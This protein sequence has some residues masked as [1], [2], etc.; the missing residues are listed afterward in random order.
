M[1]P[2]LST[3]HELP[4]IRRGWPGTHGTLTFEQYDESGRLRAGRIHADGTVTLAEYASDPKLPELAPPTAGELVVHR[5]GKRGVIIYEHSVRKF[6]RPQ[7]VESVA[8]ATHAAHELCAPTGIRTAQVIT[9]TPGSLSTEKLPGATL[10]QLAD[11]GLAGWRRFGQL[12]PEVVRQRHHCAR[13]HHATSECQ[14]LQE[15]LG[16]ATRFG[17]IPAPE[18]CQQLVAEICNELQQP[19]GE[20]VVCHRDLHDK[21]LLWDGHDL[22]L[23]DTD[24]LTMAEAALDLGNLLAHAELRY[25]QG[26]LSAASLQQVRD[27]LHTLAATL[28]VPQ[29]RLNAYTRSAAA[30]L[31]FVY[32]FRPHAK[33]WLA[34][35]LAHCFTQ[36]RKETE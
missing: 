30:R 35:W 26:V 20:L 15:W 4:R 8:T 34:Q 14:V 5:L 22:C 12:W 25:L 28:E 36:Q 9:T 24:T 11:D 10:H 7:R 21:Q 23:L 13:P 3:L 19:Q 6:L 16:H 2:A 27:I 17:A 31:A 1:N 33:P 18:R 29:Q 32:A